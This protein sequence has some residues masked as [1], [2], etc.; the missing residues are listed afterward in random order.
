MILVRHRRIGGD[1]PGRGQRSAK[2]CPRVWA[3]LAFGA[4]VALLALSS[5]A[6]TAVDTTQPSGDPAPEEYQGSTESFSHAAL[7]TVLQQHLRNGRVDYGALA[8]HPAP[9]SRY[10]HAAAS[11]QP[12]DW[13]REE[14]IAFWVNV[15]NAR[16]LEGVIRRPGLESVL[17]VGKILV[18]PTLGFFRESFP[19]ADRELSLNDIEHGI[20]RERYQEPRIHFV[21]NCASLSCPI[22][23]ERPLD[24]DSLD[25]QL[26]RATQRF[27]VDRERNRIDPAGRL[28]LSAIFKWYGDDFKTSDG[29]VQAFIEKHWPEKETFV[30]DLPVHFLD[31]DWSLNGNW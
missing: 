25:I 9:L 2:V 31:Y 30:D 1:P 11:A 10:L 27:L 14:Q 8:R 22:L 17:D 6:R 18:V 16:V 7:D 28:E 26:E 20:L 4:L 23:P 21:L 24:A 5:S 19:V 12:D 15:Y 13:T 3:L 29:S